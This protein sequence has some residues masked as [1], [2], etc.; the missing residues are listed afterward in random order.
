MAC[1]TPLKM[2]RSATPNDNG[3]RG[4]TCNPIKALNSHV[5]QRI[6]CNACNGCRSDRRR[7][8]ALRVLHECKTRSCCYFVTLTQDMEHRLPSNSLNL[9]DLQ[10]FHK[11]VRQRY[12]PGRNA[13]KFFACGEYGQKDDNPHYHSILMSDAELFPDKKLWTKDELGPVYKSAQLEEMWPNGI[14]EF[15]PVSY[16]T[17][18]YVAGYCSKKLLKPDDASLVRLSPVDGQWHHVAPEFATMSKN[19]GLGSRWFDLYGDDAFPSDFL[20]VDGHKVKP[21]KFYFDKLKTRNVVDYAHVRP[22]HALRDLG[23]S[24]A[25]PVIAARRAFA[26]TPE[27]RANCTPERLAVRQELHRLKLL[28]HNRV[29]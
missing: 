6:P 17:A 19:P 5:V 20:V 25:S 13:L 15:S 29:L 10:L 2:F 9:R 7:Q 28:R 8:M 24:D 12:A 4:L 18:M 22:G 16:A 1:F 11:R 21:P 23:R 14:A 26:S 27:A 3:K